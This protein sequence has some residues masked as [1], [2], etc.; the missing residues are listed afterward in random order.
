MI[1]CKTLRI[2]NGSLTTSCPRVTISGGSR[3]EKS[4][5]HESDYRI[6]LLALIKITDFNR[7]EGKRNAS[8]AKEKK[9]TFP[10]RQTH[11][12]FQPQIDCIIEIPL[13]V[14]EKLSNAVQKICKLN[15]LKI[16]LD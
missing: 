4:V 16:D 12:S 9:K 13:N 6:L 7:F 5:A 10:P 1:T 15:K 8:G 11:A 14:T 3:E 2:P